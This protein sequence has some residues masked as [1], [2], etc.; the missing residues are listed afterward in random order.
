MPVVS[1]RQMLDWLDGRNDSSFGGI[2]C[3]G[4]RAALHDPARR[5]GR[6]G[7]EAMVPVAGPDRRARRASPA[8]GAPVAT[9]RRTVKGVEYAVFAAAAG[10]Y[11]ATYGDARRR[12]PSAPDTTISESR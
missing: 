6:R 5:R 11:V 9:P 12:R 2:A 3:A 1:A 8:A 10:D 7:L 4:N